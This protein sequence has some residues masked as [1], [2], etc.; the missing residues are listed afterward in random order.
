[1]L[2]IHRPVIVAA[3][4]ELQQALQAPIV[5]TDVVVVTVDRTGRRTLNEAIN[6]LVNQQ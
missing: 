3:R 1:M 5:G 2:A 6:A 4:A